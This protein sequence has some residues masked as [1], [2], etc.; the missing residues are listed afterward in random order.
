MIYEVKGGRRES[1]PFF[2]DKINKIRDK[3]PATLSD[4]SFLKMEIVASNVSFKFY[5]L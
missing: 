5:Q 2:L 4:K 3:L 1:S